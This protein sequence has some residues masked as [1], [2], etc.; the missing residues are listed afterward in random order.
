MTSAPGTPG[1][2]GG[3]TRDVVGGV[4]VVGGG[5]VVVVAAVVDV[6]LSVARTSGRE[7]SDEHAETTKSK[8]TSR[9]R[10]GTSQ[11]CP[12]RAV[13]TLRG[14]TDPPPPEWG[15]PPP[16]WGTPPP[17][18][19]P[20][21][22]ASPPGT[23]GWGGPPPPPMPRTNGLAI[24]SLVCG[25]AGIAMCLGPLGSVPALITGYNARR[26]ID[27]TG[28]VQEGRGMAIAGIVLGWVGVGL[29]IIVVVAIVLVAI[30]GDPSDTGGYYG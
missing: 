18:S 20:P 8:A 30:F 21:G 7:S 26:Q 28:G 5:S 22:W 11:A 27:A 24:A 6:V 15:A 9:P 12:T 13:D 23:P 17:L 29:F 14:I 1:V 10:T 25:I 19:G 16:G 2:G 3:P 4:A